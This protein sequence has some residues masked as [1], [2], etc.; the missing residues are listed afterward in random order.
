[1]L[2]DIRGVTATIPRDEIEEALASDQPLDLILD[3]T[4][5]KDGGLETTDI[6]VTWQ[7]SDLESLLAGMDSDAITLS[8]DRAGLERVPSQKIE[9]VG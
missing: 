2:G 1:M 3:L 6:T 8:F 4:W 5:P 9:L 7:R